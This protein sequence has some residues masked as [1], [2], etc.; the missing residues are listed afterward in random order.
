MNYI[1]ILP[2]EIERLGKLCTFKKDA[3]LYTANSSVK[4]CYY[5]L[6]GSA[7][8][9]VDHSNGRRSVIDF[10]SEQDWLGELSLFCTETDVKENTV[11]ENMQCYV[12]E[13][14]ALRELCLANA[15][16]CAYF[17]AYISRKL[18]NRT[19]RMSESLNYS[20]ENR[21][22][23]FMLQYQKN[24]IYRIA[25]THASEY[26]NVSYRHVLHVMRKLVDQGILRKTEGKGYEIIDLAALKK[27][28]YSLK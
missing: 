16:V 24:G 11:L 17:T 15:Q 21:L 6:S 27:L 10:V 9:Y 14:S 19:Y 1:D 3:H 28:V 20:L 8:I 2:K 7:K 22:A 26:L 25:H 12:F 18:L 5:I 13:L 4:H 23:S